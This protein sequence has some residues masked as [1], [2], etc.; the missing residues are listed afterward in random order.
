MISISLQD[1]YGILT[2]LK[3]RNVIKNSSRNLTNSLRVRLLRGD[4]FRFLFVKRSSCRRLRGRK[5]FSICGHS[6]IEHAMFDV[7]LIVRSHIYTER[8]YLWSFEPFSGI[9][10]IP[11]KCQEHRSTVD[12]TCPVHKLRSKIRSFDCRET[13]HGDNKYHPC[14]S[15]K[16]DVSRISAK[17]PRSG[18]KVV[19]YEN[20]FYCYWSRERNILSNGT[21]RE[22]GADSNR[23]SK[24]Q[25]I[26]KCPNKAIKP[27]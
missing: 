8:I 21:N 4:C 26:E 18:A 23:T 10:S 3:I 14:K 25:K 9:N 22:N 19:A 1:I 7:N 5:R 2:T 15:T 11:Y 16:T 27:Y 6:S 17:V 20:N 13:K 24:L 12:Q